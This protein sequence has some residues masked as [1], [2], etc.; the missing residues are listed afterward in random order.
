MITERKRWH[1]IPKIIG[2][3]ILLAVALA[4]VVPF[5]WMVSTSLRPS[6]SAFSYPPQIF[7]TSWEFSN[8]ERLFTLVPFGRYFL[9][10]V[11][12]TVFTVIG[13]VLICSMAAYAFA[14]LRF[15]GRD[16]MFIL[17]LATMMIPS[18]IILIPLYLL[19]YALGW[20][21]T[22]QGLIVPGI[23]SVFG[24]FLLR[25]AFMGVPQD[26]QDAARIDGA[27][28]W[29]IYWKIFLPLNGPA[30][31]TL[32]VFAFMGT[33]TELLWPLLIGRDQSMRTLEVGLAY[34]NSQTTA[35]QQTNWPIV[36][37]AA[38]V[39]MLPVLI[40]YI[41]AQRYFVQGIAL[42]GVKG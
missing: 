5:M 9:N 27:R 39:V 41:F 6:G 7:P 17:Y 36:M 31:A 32:G 29:T 37:A 19:V 8:Y 23:S 34:F 35:F 2:Y 33:W 21:N 38:V 12:V 1:I 20:I 16:T 15:I 24:I 4:M 14:R 18:Q 25:Q 3:V 28:E 40:I 42:S 10:T 22:Y 11:I 13:Q 30:L 26:Y